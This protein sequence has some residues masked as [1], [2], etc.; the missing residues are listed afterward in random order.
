MPRTSA[1]ATATPT[2]AEAKL[3]S[4]SWVIWEKYDMVDSPAYD[5]QFVLVVKEAA[6]SNACRSTTPGRCWGLSGSRCCSRS[7]T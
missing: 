1:I 4:A 2:A 7:A 5:C 6:V 3:C